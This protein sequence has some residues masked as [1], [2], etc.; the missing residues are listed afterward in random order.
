MKRQ[1]Q[2]PTTNTRG[3]SRMVVAD[4][5]KRTCAHL[6]KAPDT[7]SAGE[8]LRNFER[9]IETAN[10]IAWRPP[11][12]INVGAKSSIVW[13]GDLWNAIDS[14]L[15]A[16]IEQCEQQLTSCQIATLRVSAHPPAM[17][18]RAIL[19]HHQT[20]IAGW[21]LQRLVPMSEDEYGQW[22]AYVAYGVEL[23]NHAAAFMRQ[24]R[25]SSTQMLVTE[26]SG[27]AEIA[28]A[29]LGPLLLQG[30]VDR[31]QAIHVVSLVTDFVALT[32][33]ASDISA[34][35]R[36]AWDKVNESFEGL[37]P[38]MPG[39]EVAMLFPRRFLLQASSKGVSDGGKHLKA[40][41]EMNAMRLVDDYERLAASLRFT[42]ALLECVIINDTQL[43]DALNLAFRTA[44]AS[45]LAGAS[46]L[47]A[48]HRRQM[49][50]LGNEDEDDEDD[51]AALAEL[52]ES[53]LQGGNEEE[54]AQLSTYDWS[55]LTRAAVTDPSVQDYLFV[56]G[57]PN[58][59]QVCY[60][61]V[62]SRKFCSLHANTGGKSRHEI[63]HAQ[64]FLPQ[65]R[66]SLLA[67][68]RQLGASGSSNQASSL[69]ARSDSCASPPTLEGLQKQTLTL[70]AKHIP[71]ALSGVQT[72]QYRQAQTQLENAARVIEA[73]IMNVS[74]TPANVWV[75]CANAIAD[76]EALNQELD[77][78]CL[79]VDLL[80]DPLHHGN[81]KGTLL[82]DELRLFSSAYTI[83]I[84]CRIADLCRNARAI[85]L[86]PEN[87]RRDFYTSWLN[88]YKP[89]HSLGH[90]PNTEAR[91]PD[92]IPRQYDATAFDAL[93][94]W[95]HFSRLAAWR[96]AEQ[97]PPARKPRQRRLSR[98]ALMSLRGKGMSV[99]QMAEHLATTPEGVQA[100]LARWDAK[101]VT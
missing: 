96:K 70:L 49:I 34:A 21:R 46:L 6:L 79:Q 86:L 61:S 4:G 42:P 80:A 44:R 65:Y 78:L 73:K 1:D 23:H 53:K 71:R 97:S 14:S 24:A 45:L 38:G 5:A 43:A 54:L 63:R 74:V 47:R 51:E 39:W 99:E 89:L 82:G 90:Q 7:A 75:A 100:A 16:A 69:D 40:L 22:R 85:S 12:N 76:L 11:A 3:R 9:Q 2:T 68:S 52:A 83:D 37:Q 19:E 17:L 62:G 93:R 98:E 8:L 67:L 41:S 87:I 64:H 48:V 20:C 33:S 77:T 72:A 59:C 55:I 35:V 91:D 28:V 50:T 29:C 27:V 26:R 30:Q 92:F 36:P 15:T 94:L 81:E 25:L 101:P 18:A 56:L 32:D 60:R 57:N 13:V 58:F 66:Q 95:E 31:E 84:L 10:V 88:G